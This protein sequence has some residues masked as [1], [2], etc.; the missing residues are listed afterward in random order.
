MTTKFDI[1][2]VVYDVDG[3]KYEVI[4]IHINQ[5]RHNIYHLKDLK[6]PS[7]KYGMFEDELSR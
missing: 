3:N 7:Y 4:E 5:L 1:G 6:N 2:E